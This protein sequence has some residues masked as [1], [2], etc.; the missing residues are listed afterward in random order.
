MPRGPRAKLKVSVASV[1]SGDTGYI[2]PIPAGMPDLAAA[3]WVE[4]VPLI[5]QVVQLRD[6]DTDALRQYCEA[7]A[8]RAK[9]VAE[10]YEPGTRLV[11]ENPNGSTFVNPLLKVIKEADAL[12]NRLSLRFGLD[13][14]SRERLKVATPRKGGALAELLARGRN[15]PKP[16]L[17]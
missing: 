8:L 15:R 5:A 9:A 14:S 2:P 17:A 4:L 10:L 12:M 6:V 11:V 16:A 3:R 7:A 13:P 1:P